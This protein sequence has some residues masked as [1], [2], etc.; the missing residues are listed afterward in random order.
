[1][2]KTKKKKDAN[3]RDW[4]RVNQVVVCVWSL[5]DLSAAAATRRER[6]Q[7][8]P[9]THTHTLAQKLFSINSFS[10]FSTLSA[11]HAF[12]K[13]K[14]VKRIVPMLYVLQS[15]S[16]HWKWMFSFGTVPFQLL[17]IANKF[18]SYDFCNDAT[19]WFK[20]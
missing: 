11:M 19:S 9:H 2:E 8:T 1:M 20:D 3:D 15:Y 13:P 12:S 7:S 18:K 5:R 10:L 16:L 4:T 17:I 6:P 14:T